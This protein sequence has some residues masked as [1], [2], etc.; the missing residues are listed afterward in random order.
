M[1]DEN[2]EDDNT[3]VLKSE[4]VQSAIKDAVSEAV[5]VATEGLEANKNGILEEKRQLSDQLKEAQQNAK[6]FEGLDMDKIKTM[7]DSMEAS[8]EAKLISEGKIDE[9]IAARTAAV[10]SSYEDKYTEKDS[11]IATLNQRNDLLQGKYE[12]KLIGDAIQ[13]EAMK[14]GMIPGAIEDAIVNSRG[15]FKIGDDGNIE[16]TKI[17][18]F[19]N[20]PERFI[21]SLKESR[22]H[23]WPSN[24]DFR[25]SGSDGGNGTDVAAQM[26]AAAS[27]GDFEAYKALRDKQAGGK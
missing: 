27:S 23:Y 15:L 16:A 9:V 3:D 5:K 11:E 17:D 14:Q 10:K 22:P 7:I 25:L 26:E 6:R 13:S 8:A 2:N 21:K 18:E 12:G 1:G 20:S 19:I 4:V 24:A